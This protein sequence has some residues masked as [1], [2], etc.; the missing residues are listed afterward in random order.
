MPCE[1]PLADDVQPGLEFRDHSFVRRPDSAVLPR[2]GPR[3]LLA[4]TSIGRLLRPLM[5][6][7][8]LSYGDE[9][10][11]RGVEHAKKLSA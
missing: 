2:L 5:D 8:E 11:G 6:L 4:G 9:I 3:W 10:V 1:P 7:G